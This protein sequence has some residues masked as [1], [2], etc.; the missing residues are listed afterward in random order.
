MSIA[1]DDPTAP[2]REG[3]TLVGISLILPV[4]P[5]AALFLVMPKLE[6]ALADSSKPLPTLTQLLARSGIPAI[7]VLLLGV[8]AI[9]LMVGS[10]VPAMAGMRTPLAAVCCLFWLL[11]ALASV[12]GIFIPYLRLQG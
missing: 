8:Q 2:V 11:A 6:P 3:R 12:I 10:R 7:A 4:I 9:L 1:P 5:V